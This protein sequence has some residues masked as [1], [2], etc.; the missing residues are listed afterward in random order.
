MQH[1][2]MKKTR[3]AVIVNFLPRYRLKFYKKLL[4]SNRV[5]VT[6]YCHLPPIALNLTSVHDQ[7]QENVRI[8]RGKFFLGEAVVFTCLPL[9]ELFFDYDIVYVEG[10]PRYV[11]F[12]LAASALRIMG[13]KVVLWGMVHSFRNKVFW[14]AVRLWWYRVFKNILVYSDAEAEYLRSLGFRSRIIGI[15]NGLDFDSISRAV[16][17]WNKEKLKTW[18]HENGIENSLVIISCARLERKNKFNQVMQILPSLTQRYPSL[19][20]CVIGAGSEREPLEQLAERLNV[21]DKVRF[22]GEIFDEA[23]QA[24]WFLSSRVFVHPGA[25]GLSLLHG[26]A[27]GLPVVTHENAL[28]HGPEFAAFEPGRH[29]E[30]F[31]EDNLAELFKCI[32]RLLS[33]CSIS[34]GMGR[35]AQRAVGQN[36]TTDVMVERFLLFSNLN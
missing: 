29:G 18:K 36:Y 19:V 24:P 26:M 35:D 32:I 34:A 22:L 3:V 4:T 15:N 13:R 20:W 33:S 30:V 27:F 25:I 12:A 2:S 17:Q 10:N 31:P 28:H 5:E 1:D 6:I 21:A 8:L 7:L 9:R 16:R 14:Q 11:S 23:E